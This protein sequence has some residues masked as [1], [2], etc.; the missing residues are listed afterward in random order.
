MQSV[1]EWLVM[2]ILARVQVDTRH[3]YS[4]YRRQIVSRCLL[5]IIPNLTRHLIEHPRLRARVKYGCFCC[6]C[7]SRDLTSSADG[8][9]LFREALIEGNMENYFRLA[10]QFRTQDDPAFCG[11][12]TLTMVLNALAIDPGR[13]WKGA[14]T[15][16]PVYI[17]GTAVTP[18]MKYV[19]VTLDILC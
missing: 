3:I 6:C 19:L 2:R 16:P 13:T 1:Y 18:R 10:E 5:I 8:R 11:I 4:E 15:N 12:S 17:P 9:K 7:C 14:V